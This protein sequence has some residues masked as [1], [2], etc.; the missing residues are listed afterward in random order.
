VEEVELLS[1]ER[2]GNRMMILVEMQNKDQNLFF[3]FLELDRQPMGRLLVEQEVE[4]CICMDHTHHRG[5]P[6]VQ[7]LLWAVE[8][9]GL[10]LACRMIAVY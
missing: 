8:V 6:K 1:L 4:P 9:E 10:L 5:L 3:R 2:V 7:A